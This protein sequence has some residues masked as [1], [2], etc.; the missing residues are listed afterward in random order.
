MFA[1]S[2]I[3]RAGDWGS[4]FRCLLWKGEQEEIVPLFHW[5]WGILIRVALKCLKH[6][7]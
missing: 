5:R 3:T 2:G 6:L 4:Y 7:V 1:G